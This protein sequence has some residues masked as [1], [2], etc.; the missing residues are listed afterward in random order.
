MTDHHGYIHR[1][2]ELAA[3]A[4]GLVA[5]NPMVG[6]VLVY[7]NTIIGEGFHERF[8]EEHAEVNCL[9]SVKENDRHL[10]P[11]S[12]MYVS[13]EPCAHYGKTPPCALRL[14]Q[15]NIKQVIVCNDDP[16][17]NVN[18]KGFDILRANDIVIQNG[19][20]AKEGLWLNRRFF[21]FHQQ[22]RPYIILKWAQTQQ[23]FFAPLNR[24][25]FQM[26]NMHSQQL[27]HKWRTEEA[28]IF[29]G[30]KTALND[31]PQLTARLWKGTNPLRIVIDRRLEL[32]ESLQL[33]NK[34][35]TTWI[36]N[37]RKEES[38]DNK[39]YIQLDFGESVIKQLLQ[40]LHEENILSLIVE[41]GATLLRSFIDGNLWDEVRVFETENILHE[42]IA[43]PLFSNANQAFSSQ[44]GTDKLHVYV[45]K[46]SAYQYVQEMEL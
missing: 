12:T 3:K 43:A 37:E 10:I 41:G 24:S 7:N 45:N 29:V 36:I 34:D 11:Q 18:G 40:K 20:L 42:G 27:V 35:A 33:F 8:G 23:G 9:K 4:K 38:R 17:D 26:S 5:P 16:F 25:R 19:I 30:T 13:L 32:P 46:Q 15:E 31:D 6:A 44:L 28:A 21:C 2:L 39:R 14:V 1:C 22:K